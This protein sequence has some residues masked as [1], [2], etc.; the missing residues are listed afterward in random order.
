MNPFLHKLQSSPRVSVGTFIM[1]ASPLIAEAVGCCG[2]D[3]AIVDGEHSPVDTMDIAHMLQA[4]GTTPTVPIVRMAWNDPV[5]VKRVLDAGAPTLLFPFIQDAEA[6]RRAVL[7]TRYP[8]EGIRGMAGLSRASRFGAVPDHFRTANSRVG[9]I[10]QLETQAALDNLESIAAVPG[11][12]ALFVGPT[13]LSGSMGH[14]GNASHP[15]VQRAVREFARRCRTA[16]KPAG[17]LATNA[18][19]A[20]QFAEEGFSFVA[21]G[22][23]LGLL[24]GNARAML[25]RL[26]EVAPPPAHSPGTY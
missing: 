11:V 14:G 4:L 6:A 20:K 12:D 15:E 7:A 21:V 8:P 24:T 13:D 22:S 26:K 19:Q 16:G 2:F 1:S 17:T 10:V 9:V 23:D 18:D 3:W 25:D 5:L